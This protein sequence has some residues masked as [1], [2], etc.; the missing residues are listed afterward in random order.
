MER[1]DRSA[2]EN[3]VYRLPRLGSH[4]SIILMVGISG[5]AAIVGW[6]ACQSDDSLTTIQ[7]KD[8]VVQWLQNNPKLRHQAAASLVAHAI[9]DA[10]P[11]PQ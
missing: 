5:G 9:A 1:P 7:I 10:F 3:H 4:R 6:R 2:L 11:C 8:V